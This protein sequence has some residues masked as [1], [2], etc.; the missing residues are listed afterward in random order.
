MPHSFQ[1][2]VKHFLHL[3]GNL[4]CTQCCKARQI[5]KTCLLKKKKLDIDSLSANVKFW[6]FNNHTTCPWLSQL[7]P[8]LFLFHPC[9]SLRYPGQSLLHAWLSLLYRC[10]SLAV[11]GIY[12]ILSLS[13]ECPSVYTAL[14]PQQTVRL[15]C[16][17][18]M[19]N[20]IMLKPTNQQFNSAYL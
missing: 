6:Y 17:S 1:T 7:C 4:F 2:K 16:S 15:S 9:L 12:D 19:F 10:I 20:G 13:L 18:S 3:Q 8:S 14:W 5:L 11:P